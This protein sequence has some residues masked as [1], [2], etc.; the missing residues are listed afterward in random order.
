MRLLIL[1]GTGFL[2][3]NLVKFYYNV[4]ND[5]AVFSRDEAKHVDLLHNYPQ[6]K[7]YIGDIR[8]K[9]SLEDCIYSFKPDH[10]IVASAMKN[11]VFAESYPIEAVNTNIHGLHNLLTVIRQYAS[12]EKPINMVFVSTDKASSPTNVYGMTKSICEQMCL[13]FESEGVNIAVVR[14]GNVLNS[15]GSILPVLKSALKTSNKLPSLTHAHMTRFLMHVEDAIELIDY[16]FTQSRKIVIPE[17]KSMY[18]KDLY[19]IIAEKYNVTFKEGQIRPGEKIHE[20]L[21]SR[22]EL[23]KYKISKDINRNYWL[24]SLSPSCAKNNIQDLPY[25]CDAKYVVSK[26]ELKKILTNYI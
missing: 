2:G 3:K 13:S 19:E 20:S 4:R 6:V 12:K 10:I 22:E 16:A 15:T 21:I 5:I 17:L 11:I 18:I 14:Y 8:N 23:G 25:S 1:G 7:S 24:L 9:A 26:S